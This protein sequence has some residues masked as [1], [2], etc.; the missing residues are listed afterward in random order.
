MVERG[1]DAAP[2]T[3][4]ENSV[5]HHL[6]LAAATLTSYGPKLP[7]A[8]GGEDIRVDHRLL[9]QSRL[10][11]LVSAAFPEAAHREALRHLGEA[12]STVVYLD[13]AG[14]DVAPHLGAPLGE[15]ARGAKDPVRSGF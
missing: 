5:E 14:L 12:L 4:Q 8:P 2:C 9:H 15:V 1:A 10:R 6:D 3:A 13:L 7:G 11:P